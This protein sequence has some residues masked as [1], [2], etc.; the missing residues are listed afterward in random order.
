[1]WAMELLILARRK[2][3]TFAVIPTSL[4]PREDLRE[5]KVANLA[6]I[7]KVFRDILDLRRRLS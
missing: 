6:T 1:M 2:G 4:R 3:A 7:I 5:S